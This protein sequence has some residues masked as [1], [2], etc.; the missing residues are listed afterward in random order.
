MPW[1]D[2][3]ICSKCAERSDMISGNLFIDSQGS[4]VVCSTQSRAVVDE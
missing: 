2:M 1:H 3:A 4:K